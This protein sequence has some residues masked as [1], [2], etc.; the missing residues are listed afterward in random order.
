MPSSGRSPAA[1]AVQGEDLSGQ[2]GALGGVAHGSAEVRR[3]AGALQEGAVRQVGGLGIARRQ[4]GPQGVPHH[5]QIRGQLAGQAR[6]QAGEAGL[7]GT[8][9]QAPQPGAV[10]GRVQQDL[11]AGAGLEARGEGLG[12]EEGE[13]QI[14]APGGL[15]P[16]CGPAAEGGL[17]EGP[18]HQDCAGNN[19][20]SGLE[21]I[22]ICHHAGNQVRILCAPLQGLNPGSLRQPFHPRSLSP[23]P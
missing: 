6:H 17:R 12:A 3:V 7:G 21:S 1:A 16:L 10:D 20:V 23:G 5:P 15:Q 13:A 11:Q 2:E 4:D 14:G 19:P 9:G 22:Q 18:S 8:V